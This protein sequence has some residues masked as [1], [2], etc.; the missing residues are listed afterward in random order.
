MYK[1][2]P[3]MSAD[4]RKQEYHSQYLKKIQHRQE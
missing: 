2:Q 3:D 4:S 1:I